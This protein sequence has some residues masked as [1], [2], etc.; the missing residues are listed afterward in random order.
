MTPHPKPSKP[1]RGT[2]DA[3]RWLD[4]IMRLSCICCTRPAEVAHHPIHGRFAQ[5][6]SSDLDAL[7]MCV[8]HHTMLHDRPA[9]WRAVF[10]RDANYL[11]AVRRSVENLRANTIGGRS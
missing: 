1:I 4:A 6:K 8:F 11:P 10:G 7:P 3:K 5:R 9:D 2:A